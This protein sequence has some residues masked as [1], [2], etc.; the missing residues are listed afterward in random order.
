MDICTET[1]ATKTVELKAAQVEEIIRA[2]FSGLGSEIEIEW[3]IPYD[4]WL[5]DGWLR[6]C[7]VSGVTRS[8]ETSKSPQ[9]A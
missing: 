6:G 4:G 9:N 1:K 8:Q 3:D 2:H 5:R 7:I